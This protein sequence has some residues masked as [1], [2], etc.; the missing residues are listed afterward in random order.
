MLERLR[1]NPNKAIIS[2]C[3]IFILYYAL[4]TLFQLKILPSFSIN[5]QDLTF[6]AFQTTQILLVFPLILLIS[7][8][9]FIR[10]DIISWKDIGFNKGKNGLLFTIFIGISG[11]FFL[12]LFNFF[13]IDYFI[14]RT[15]VISNFFEKCLFA[16]I[17]E[18]FYYRVLLL[19]ILEFLF[20]TF[21]KKKVFDN[22]IYRDKFSESK[23]I[24]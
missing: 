2:I 14:L 21:V 5:V 17:W 11:G 16:P 20:I 22:P 7:Y 10:T 19:T 24:F 4:I 8:V 18:E 9:A 3:W 23:K 12:G 6:P 1:E 15:D 13:T